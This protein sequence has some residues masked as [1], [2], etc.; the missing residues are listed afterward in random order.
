MVEGDVKNFDQGVLFTFLEEYMSFGL[1]YDHPNN[2]FLP[3]RKKLTRFIIKNLVA[4][5][6]HLFGPVWGIQ[7]GGMP[8]G[9]FNTSHGDSWMMALWFYMFLVHQIDRAPDDLKEKLEEAALRMIIIVYGDDHAWNRTLDSD[10]STYFSGVEFA[11]FMSEAF[12]IP[13]R[14]LE[15]GIPFCSRTRNGFIVEKGLTFLRHQF[16]L[17]HN[18]SKGQ[19]TFLPFREANEY[20][21]RVVHGRGGKSTAR[22]YVDVILS[23]LG[24]A[25]GTFGSN[26]VALQGI[27]A[28][29][30]EALASTGLREKQVLQQV[31][32]S[33]SHDDLHDLRRKGV[34]LEEV[35]NGFPTQAAL[36]KKNK[37]DQHYQNIQLEV[38]Q[39]W[40]DDEWID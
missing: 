27:E 33:L 9:I 13:I 5:I 1:V 12:D 17:N 38:H 6:T 15:D 18:T 34:T 24:H 29:Y 20:W 21:I 14:D 22:T 32:D 37:V 39:T 25:Y 11:R 10:I 36:E 16:V 19:S 30:R 31:V 26:Q 40:A 2:P 8:S 35:E 23:C 3:Y 4:R 7:T 28:I